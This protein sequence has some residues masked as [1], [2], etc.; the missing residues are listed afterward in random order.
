MPSSSHGTLREIL[1]I[2]INLESGG[3]CKEL[4]GSNAIVDSGIANLREIFHAEATAK[5]TE[6]TGHGQ[7][8]KDSQTVI[9]EEL[10]SRNLRQETVRYSL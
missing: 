7:E 5:R 1:C 9:E 3:I 2:S 4:F 8:S 10:E 6:N